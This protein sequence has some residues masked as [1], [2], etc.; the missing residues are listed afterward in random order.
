MDNGFQSGIVQFKGTPSSATAFL[1][2]FYAGDAPDLGQPTHAVR[3]D[4]IADD[5][6]VLASQD[7][8]LDRLWLRPDGR[9]VTVE[10]ILRTLSRIPAG[11][12][13]AILF[14]RCYI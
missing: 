9:S 13:R 2:L 1:R 5:K 11:V 3:F 7:A 6:T 12:I 8:H 4:L 10:A 14:I